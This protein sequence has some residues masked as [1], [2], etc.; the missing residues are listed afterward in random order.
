MWLL[1]QVLLSCEIRRER[2]QP[3][4]RQSILD[5]S[6][7]DKRSKRAPTLDNVKIKPIHDSKFADAPSMEHILDWK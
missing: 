1:L 5:K 2:L 3:R 7:H 4:N 6:G